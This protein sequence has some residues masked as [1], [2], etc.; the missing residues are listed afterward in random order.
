MGKIIKI[1]NILLKN[2]LNRQIRQKSAQG[3]KIGKKAG[4]RL[5]LATLDMT[6]PATCQQ[7]SPYLIENGLRKVKPYIHTFET[8]AKNYMFKKKI[9]SFAADYGQ[10]DLF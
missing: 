10:T 6:L 7:L 5:R 2:R 8:Y 1:S 4:N 3:S 9:I